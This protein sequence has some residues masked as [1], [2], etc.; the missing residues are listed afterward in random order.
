[1]TLSSIGS[2]I[3]NVKEN[4]LKPIV[5]GASKRSPLLPDVPTIVEAGGNADTLLPTYFGFAVPHGTPSAVK[6]RLVSLLQATVNS[7][8]TIRQLQ[9]LG[10]E[11]A[12]AQPAEMDATVKAD[13]ERFKKIV[14]TLSIQQE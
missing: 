2:L 9:A 7:P 14:T 4:R 6:G 5:L 13:I 8:E 12:S 1:M 11:P 3:G 10:M